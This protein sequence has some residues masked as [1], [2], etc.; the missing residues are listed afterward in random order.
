MKKA[1]ILVLVLFIASRLKAQ[2]D[3]IKWICT[4]ESNIWASQKSPGVTL[5]NGQKFDVEIRAEMP[6]QRINGFGGCFNEQGWAALKLLSPADR[7]S[8]FKEL[9]SPGYGASFSICRM[10]LGANDFSLNWYSYDEYDQDFGMAKFSIHRD[11]NTLVPF[12]KF[13]LAYNPA[14]KFWASPWSPPQWMKKNRHYAGKLVSPK[15]IAQHIDNGLRAGREGHEGSDMFIQSPKYFKA[16]AL[17]FS[18]FIDEYRK[19][20]VNITMVMPQNEF[21]SAQIFPSCTWTAHGLGDFIHY[22]GPQMKA[23]GVAVFLG[24]VERANEKLVDTILKDKL[25]RSYIQGAGFQWSGKGAI[26]GIHQK[27]PYLTLYQSEQECGD[28]KNDWSYCCYTWDLM[29]QYFGAGANAYMYWNLALKDGGV[30]HWGWK[31]NSLITVDTIARTYKY[32]Y[33]YYLLKHISHFVKPGARLLK[34]SG[35]LNDILVFRNPD[36]TT[37]IVIRNESSAGKTIVLK[38]GDKIIEPLL[39]ADSFNTIVVENAL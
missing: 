16:Y 1:C 39:K 7:Q 22:L 10:P 13:A 9:F 36:Q 8:I 35:D 6:G 4:T 23:K 34:T 28:G 37:V 18:K 31:Q 24:T 19:I 14:L 38:I 25:C 11:L 32:N 26:A 21:N 29:K 30:S 20:G 33:E 3:V 5:Y 15:D 12:I 27:Y 2:S 17:Y